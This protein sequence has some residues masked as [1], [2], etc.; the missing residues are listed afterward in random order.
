MLN[1]KTKTTISVETISVGGSSEEFLKS[2]H[3]KIEAN[4]TAFALP[5]QAFTNKDNISFFTPKELYGTAKDPASRMMLSA[6][7]HHFE[8]SNRDFIMRFN[9]TAFIE[10]LSLISAIDRS[11]PDNSEQLDIIKHV[12]FRALHVLFEGNISDV[13]ETVLSGMLDAFEPSVCILFNSE[14]KVAV[15]ASKTYITKTLEARDSSPCSC[16]SCKKDRAEF[17]D[18]PEVN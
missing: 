7:T 4:P 17:M 5:I 2:F 15:I 18:N 16:A 14:G 10:G 13:P 6:L 3:E 11:I 8:H 1:D 12:N 9:I